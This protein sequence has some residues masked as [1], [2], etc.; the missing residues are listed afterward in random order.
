MVESALLPWL[1][2]APDDLR[3]RCAEIDAMAQ[4]G[5]AMRWLAGHALG[6]NDLQRLAR[7]I[8]RAVNDGRAAPLQSFEL[9]LISN[10]TTDFIVPAL[11]GSAARHGIALRVAASPF[12]M[13][14]QAALDPSSELLESRLDA[15]LLALDYRA[16]FSDYALDDDPAASVTAAIT[17]LQ[18]MIGAL[19]DVSKAAVIVQTIAAPPERLF[20]SLDRGQPGTGAWLAAAFNQRLSDEVLRPGVNL[21]DME[22]LAARVG[23]TAWFDRSQY[24][25]ARL[26]FASRFIPLYAEHAARL[27]GAIRGHSRKVLVLDLDNTLWGGIIGDDG[28]D[29]I[30]LGQGDPRGEAHQDLQRAA[31][32]LKRRGILL[33]VSS[34]N[35]EAL[36]RQAIREHPEMLL[37]EEDFSAMQM[38]WSDK[39]TNLEVL[40][41]RLSL[42]LDSFVFV[43][44]NP[45]ERAQVRSALPQ[46]L[47]LELPSDPSE[48]A[49]VLLASGAFE[50]IGFSDEDR[51]RSKHYA[52]NARRDS[53]AAQSRDLAGFLESLQ[54]RA[55]FV[56]AGATGWSRF[57]QLI[58]KSNQFN[59]TTK[60]YSE[61]QVAN[62]VAAPDVLTLQVRLADQ[63]GDNGLIC[64]V[65]ACPRDGAWVL[66]TWVLSCRVLG[67][68]VEEA[69]LNE[70][71]RRARAA[72]IGHLVGLYR[73]TSRNGLVRDHYR[74][75]GFR[76]EGHDGDTERWILDVASFEPIMLP[77]ACETSPDA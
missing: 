49:A 30:R 14:I 16:Y 59:L 5:T 12:G 29:R 50:S 41:E 7:S 44:D 26:P 56:A 13:T 39:A 54:M 40:A 75:L 48:Y 28:I 45:V 70:I 10:N 38:N 64:S 47:V 25:T 58:N 27:I 6:A 74:K 31:L 4:R 24:M 15:I 2:A 36:A 76:Q 66:D 55:T 8:T 19:A 22:A 17:K 37:R 61:A 34:K 9:G 71:V 67:R 23:L 21:L 60:R 42:G 3:A 69:V 63:F 65:I 53:L 68:R 43:D 72:G 35:D 46:V 1:P 20:G 62:W 57:T 73:A 51:Q 52:A 11:I 18:A 77:I 33:A 32:A